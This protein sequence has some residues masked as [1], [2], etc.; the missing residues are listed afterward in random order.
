MQYEVD[1]NKKYIKLNIT[2]IININ[3]EGGFRVLFGRSPFQFNMFKGRSQ[4]SE[5]IL[6]LA[7]KEGRQASPRKGKRE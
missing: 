7:A 4:S 5:V 1:K 2:Y 6:N 3:D